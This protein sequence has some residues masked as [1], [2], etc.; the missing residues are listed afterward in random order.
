MQKFYVGEGEK[1]RRRWPPA[2]PEESLLYQHPHLSET[3]VWLPACLSCFDL[4]GSKRNVGS[5]II[6]AI[7]YRPDF[8]PRPSLSLCLSTRRYE[9]WLTVSGDFLN[10][11]IYF[12]AFPRKVFLD[13]ENTQSVVVYNLHNFSTHTSFDFRVNS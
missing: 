10:A 4:T 12:G 11:L 6:Q 2:L 9:T 13:R 1:S 3:A 5:C 8:S 7:S